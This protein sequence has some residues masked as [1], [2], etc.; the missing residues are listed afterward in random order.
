MS[1]PD[2]AQVPRRV[3]FR[4]RWYDVA[5]GPLQAFASRLSGEVAAGAEFTCLLTTAEELE[6]LNIR[7][8]SKSGSTDVLSFPASQQG[9]YLGDMAISLPHARAQ[10]KEFGHGVHE[11]ICVL[12][13]HGLLHLVGM[14]HETDSG[15]MRRAETRWRKKLGL[16]VGLI[17]RTQ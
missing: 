6:E 14:D 16:P 11:E 17:A 10:A 3:I 8:R 1:E 5:S 15:A 7:F 12:M 9:E 2:P 4:K 13:L